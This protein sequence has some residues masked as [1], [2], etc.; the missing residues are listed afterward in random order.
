VQEDPAASNIGKY[1][2]AVSLS[3]IAL[4]VLLGITMRIVGRFRK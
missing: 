1:V 4:Q 2:L 3:V